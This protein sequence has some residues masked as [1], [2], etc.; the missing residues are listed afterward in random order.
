M[1]HVQH[2]LR[3]L[4]ALSLVLIMGLFRPRAYFGG[5]WAN[6]GSCWAYFGGLGHVGPILTHFRDFFCEVLVCFGSFWPYFGGILAVWASLAY[7]REFLEGVGVFS[8]ILG[9]WGHYG[10]NLEGFGPL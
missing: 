10:P 4:C 5:F 8:A 1:K 9:I 7:F 2:E 3:K 6:L